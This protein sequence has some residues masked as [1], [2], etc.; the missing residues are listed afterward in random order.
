[1]KYNIG[2]EIGAKLIQAAIIDKY[3]RLVKRDKMPSHPERELSAIVS[4]AAALIQDLVHQEGLDLRSAKSIGVACPG[5]LDEEGTMIIKNYIMG[6]HNAPIRDEFRKHFNLPI[7]VENDAHCAAL[8]ESVSGAAEDLDYSMTI[9]IG[10]GIS[11]G[12]IIKNQIYAGFNGGGAIVSH[13]VIDKHGKECYCGRKGCLETVCSARALVQQTTAYAQQHPE[14]MIHKV[15]GGDLSRIDETTAYEAFELGDAGAKA[16]FDEYVDNLS[17]ALINVANLLM[18]EV[19]IL[20]G[21]ITWL[22]EKLLKPLREKLNAGVFAKEAGL[23]ML[24][25]SEMGSAS[26]LVGAGML[27]TYRNR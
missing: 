20:C 15:C 22:G 26:V 6:F 5:F 11:S 19:I 25:Q 17:V 1:M 10:T 2:V 3:G 9:N 8:A 23:P 7:Y 24:R 18:P 14:S 13:M 4:D 21:G 12:I 16:I 27:G